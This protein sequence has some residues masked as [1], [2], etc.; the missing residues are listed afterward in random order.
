LADVTSVPQT[1]SDGIGAGPTTGREPYTLTNATALDAHG[2]PSLLYIGAEFCPYCAAERWALVEAL[3]RFG[4]FSGLKQITSSEDKISTF[5]FLDAT[6][7]SKYLNFE[8]K[9]EEDQNQKP[10]QSLTST[11]KAQWAKYP[12]P[13]Q[14]GEGFPFLDF[15]GQSVSAIPL[16]DPTIVTG[17]SWSQIASSLK[18][19]STDVS[20]WINGAANQITAGICQMTNNAPTSVCTAAVTALSQSFKPYTAS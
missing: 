5:T 2:K 14:T 1:V 8:S 12:I 17:K 13:G 10:L 19:P 11:E 20:K 15:N 4:S 16:V 6:Y 18:D 3:S 7:T 9:E